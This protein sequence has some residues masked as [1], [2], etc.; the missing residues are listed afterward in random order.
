MTQQSVQEHEALVQAHDLAARR[1]Q[2][3]IL[4]VESRGV[5][6]LEELSGALGVS[7]AT[8][9]RDLNAIAASGR[10]RR[11]HGGAVAADQRPDEPHFDVKAAA[12]TAEK[13][14]IAARIRRRL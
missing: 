12:A 4:L 3:L 14:R 13:Q 6:R 8:V 7:Q 10:L 11:V 1:R 9:R 5:A 2:R